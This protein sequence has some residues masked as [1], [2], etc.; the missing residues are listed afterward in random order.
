MLTNLDLNQVIKSSTL[1]EKKSPTICFKLNGANKHAFNFSGIEPAEGQTLG[2]F[3]DAHWLD[4]D[5]E[6]WT[7]KDGE[8]RKN[9][10]VRSSVN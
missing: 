10:T 6:E 5:L 4:I 9:F 2:E 8:V 7:T 1:G 3:L